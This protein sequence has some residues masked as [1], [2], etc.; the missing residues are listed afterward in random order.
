MPYSHGVYF[1]DCPVLHEKDCIVGDDQSIGSFG[2][3]NSVTPPINEYISLADYVPTDTAGNYLSENPGSVSK[4]F[5]CIPDIYG[6]HWFN[7]APEVHIAEN[8]AAGVNFASAMKNPETLSDHLMLSLYEKAKDSIEDPSFL[9]AVTTNSFLYCK[10]GGFIVPITS[11]QE[12]NNYNP[13]ENDPLAGLTYGLEEYIKA[14]KENGINPYYPGTEE[15]FSY[16]GEQYDQLIEEQNNLG[17]IPYPQGTDMSSP[18]WGDATNQWVETQRRLQAAAN[19]Q[20]AASLKDMISEYKSYENIP[21]E[22]KTQLE[23]LKQKHDQINQTAFPKEENKQYNHSTVQEDLEDYQT[24]YGN[25]TDPSGDAKKSWSES[26]GETVGNNAP[27]S[28]F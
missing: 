24:R 8:T 27:Y 11:G 6:N 14:A 7:T 25:I 3:C 9:E 20:Y 28:L 22:N 12:P 19:E 1:K 17:D 15:Y 10:H 18:G 13:F 16:E 4:G 26:V 21:E 5:K 23:T 2:H